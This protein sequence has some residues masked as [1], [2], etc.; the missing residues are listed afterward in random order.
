MS[1]N[2]ITGY[3]AY[4]Y[5]NPYAIPT[6]NTNTTFQGTA[7]IYT[8][9]TEEKNN[10]GLAIA[11]IGAAA[12]A[13]G[14]GIYALKKGKSINGADG[15]LLENLKTG[16]QE[17][18]KAIGEKVGKIFKQKDKIID[19]GYQDKEITSA[20]E[21]IIETSKAPFSEKAYNEATQAYKDLIIK[22]GEEIFADICTP[23]YRTNYDMLL[24]GR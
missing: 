20:A 23:S 19:T 12:L 9:Q 4:P 5:S 2:G 3:S 6:S 10:T 14:T 1:M 7:Q 18:G 24:K 8:D 11:G 21:K 15:K 16:F 22:K 13:I 17:I